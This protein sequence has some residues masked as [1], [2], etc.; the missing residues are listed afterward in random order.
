[1]P[2]NKVN[3]VNPNKESMGK[4]PY[5]QNRIYDTEG[6]A[7]ALCANKSDLLIKCKNE[8]FEPNIPSNNKGLILAGNM[9]GGK[10]ENVH[11]SGRRVYNAEGKAP[12]IPTMQGGNQ[13]PKTLNN[14]K[15]RRLTPLEC[16]RLQTVPDNYT[17]FC[18]AKNYLYICS[19][20]NEIKL[21][22]Q[23]AELK[24]AI[25]I[26]QIKKPNYVTNIIYDL[27]ELEQLKE[28][29]LINTKTAT[30]LDVQKNKELLL[31]IALLTTKDGL[32]MDQQNCLQKLLK[33]M[34]NVSIVIEPLAK[35]EEEQ[36]ECVID[37]TKIGLD[38]KTLYMQIIKEKK[39]NQEGTMAELV[40][41]SDTEL[42]WKITWEETLNVAKLYIILT[43]IKQIIIS[44]IYTYSKIK[45][46]I[47]AAISNCSILEQ[48]CINVELLDLRMEN[49]SLNSDTQRYKMLGN[50]W[51]VDVI[52]HI[53][54]HLKLNK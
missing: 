49:I 33:E 18:T 39:L 30:I 41:K 54:S 46:N 25:K 22:L 26:S 29:L 12:T 19:E 15:I 21:W 2:K 47:K 24:N 3:Q 44:K 52:S 34:I 50:G 40:V 11:E 37:I 32:N 13:H 10:W 28:I 20:T 1:M 16:E 27:F 31:G 14:S 4:Q 42:L 48:N 35:K 23:N 53:F 8:Y 38:I 9:R 45:T 5:Q 36:E 7:P 51:T 6:L 17:A 43:L